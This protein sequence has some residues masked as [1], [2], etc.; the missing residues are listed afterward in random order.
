M[1]KKV[2]CITRKYPPQVGGME[3]FCYNLFSGLANDELDVNIVSLGKKQINLIWFFPYTIF[4][5][6]FNIRKYDAFVI[7]DG[8]MCFLG[9]ISKLFSRRTKR[10]IIIY[11]LDILYKNPIYQLYLKLFLKKSSD[12]YVTISRGTDEA[13]AARGIKGS[14]IITPGIDITD[15]DISNI[16]LKSDFLSKYN[17]NENNLIMLTVGRLVKRKGVEW[18]INNVM[19][20]FKGKKITYL[21]IGDGEERSNIDKAIINNGL[22]NQVHML[23]RVSDEEL[24]ACYRYADVFIM[25]NI[26]V[27]NDMEGFGIVAVEASLKGLI[28]IASGI[29]GIRDAVKDGKNGY[30][31]TS[32]DPQSFISK[33]ESIMNNL[34]KYKAQTNEFAEYTRNNF[35]WKNI[36][37]KYAD[38]ILEVC[39]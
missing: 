31:L 4:Y 7:G 28:V 19:S 20:E 3:N 13:L 22:E 6:I 18:F 12:K 29:E 35:A 38:L 32:E 5:V 36:C 34:E 39:K 8:L 25:P 1:K 2:L 17:I 21:V 10:L 23:G 15:T 30:L 33:I 27:N 11:G 37:K 14:T 24:A 26:H 16:D 9:I